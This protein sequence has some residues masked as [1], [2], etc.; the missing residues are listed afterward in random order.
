MERNTLR[1]ATGEKGVSE[2]FYFVMV[3]LNRYLQGKQSDSHNK[4]LIISKGE[5][6]LDIFA[7]APSPSEHSLRAFS[8]LKTGNISKLELTVKI[9][10]D[11]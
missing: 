9:L 11:V 1:K 3:I 8:S 6:K 7:S 10:K 2:K 4:S 5:F